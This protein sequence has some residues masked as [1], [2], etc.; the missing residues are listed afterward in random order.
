MRK[1]VSVII[2]LSLALSLS[3]CGNSEPKELTCE[4]IIAAYEDAGYYVVHGEYQDDADGLPLCYIRVDLSQEPDS[5]Y[6][7][8]TTHRTE[9]KFLGAFWFKII[10]SQ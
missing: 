3:A 7:Y 10:Y 2:L 9:K 1:I 4:E 8:F 5:D 6:I